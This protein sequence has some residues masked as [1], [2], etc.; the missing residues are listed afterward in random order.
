MSAVD[1]NAFCK[2]LNE[3]K[4]L[5]QTEIFKAIESSQGD[6]SQAAW[7]LYSENEA[8]VKKVAFVFTLALMVWIAPFTT[9]VALA[10]GCAFD[11]QVMT[12][13]ERFTEEFVNRFRFLDE[14]DSEQESDYTDQIY[15]VAKG[16]LVILGA[17][18]YR[19]FVFPLGIGLFAGASF[20]AE[21][22]NLK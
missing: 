3:K 7:Q 19:S 15:L 21:Q 10:T 5:V 4:N 2:L 17:L 1:F 16:L 8:T 18:S 14:D 13:K 12:I 20:K 6:Y 9:V 22:A 11:E